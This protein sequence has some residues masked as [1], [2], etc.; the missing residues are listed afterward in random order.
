MDGGAGDDTFIVDSSDDVVVEGPN[1]G[2]D[3]V[4]A[5]VVNPEGARLN[6]G[7]ALPANVENLT[8]D[9]GARINGFGN[10]LDNVIVGS[11]AF[12]EIWA[13]AGNDTIDG[14]GVANANDYGDILRGG[15]GNDTYLVND[16]RVQVIEAANEGTDTVKASVGYTLTAQVENLILT[17]ANAISGTGNTLDNVLTGNS[18]NNSLDGGAGADAMSGGWGNDTYYVDNVGDSVN[19]QASQGTDTVVVSFSYTLPS[20]V[21]KLTLTGSAA[22]NGTGNELNNVVTGNAGNNV[23]T[24]GAGNDWL[25]GG[26]GNDTLSGGSGADIFQY[27]RGAVSTKLE[28]NGKDLILDFSPSDILRVTDESFGA[29]SFVASATNLLRNQIYVSNAGGYTLLQIGTTNRSGGEPIQ[30]TLT[31]TF[32]S[33]DFSASGTDI[34]LTNP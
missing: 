23:L 24:G 20:N 10:S 34:W 31:G 7:Y 28:D 16:S 8:I 33:S 27:A 9:Y 2:T 22:I 13:G 29:A 19:E 26:A 15:T 12:N 6:N 5:R 11:T 30:I 21:E 14:G 1:Q 4:E 18:G 32:S 3:K 17:G 25:M